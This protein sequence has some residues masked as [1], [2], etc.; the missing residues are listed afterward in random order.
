MEKIFT[1]IDPNFIKVI[2][3]NKQLKEDSNGE[4]GCNCSLGLEKASSV[5][6]VTCKKCG[7]TFRTNRK[8]DICFACE[9]NI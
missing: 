3:M 8:T 6:T 4:I 7:R 5:I 2:I 9:F 1:I